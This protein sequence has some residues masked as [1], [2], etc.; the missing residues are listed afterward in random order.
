MLVVWLY[1]FATQVFSSFLVIHANLVVLVCCHKSMDQATLVD[2]IC[3]IKGVKTWWDHSY[4][5]TGLQLHL[6]LTLTK[7][8]S[9]SAYSTGLLCC[10]CSGWDINI[11]DQF[12]CLY[13][14]VCCLQLLSAYSCW[15][16]SIKKFDDFNRSDNYVLIWE[17]HEHIKFY[18]L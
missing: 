5:H 9:S 12:Y 11:I 3:Y 6:Q 1:Q 8:E 14:N 15:H 2:F 10:S 13:R 16:C 17:L 4:Q 7:H 18:F